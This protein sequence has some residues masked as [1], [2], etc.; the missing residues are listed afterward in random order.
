LVECPIAKVIWGVLAICLHQNTRPTCYEHFWPWITKAL[1]GGE[2]VYMLGLT[3][4]FWAIWEARNRVC[5]IKKFINN[6]F[7]VIFSACAFMWYWAGLYP[8]ETWKLIKEGINLMMKIAIKL[9]G[10]KEGNKPMPTLKD[11]ESATSH[12]DDARS[13]DKSHE[14]V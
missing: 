10:E 1:P 14:G 2:K 12:E 5:F 3:T 8:E 4:I 6:P 11:N 13:K 9:V 7:E